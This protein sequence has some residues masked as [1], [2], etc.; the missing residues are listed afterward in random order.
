MYLA[1]ANGYC[2]PL[3]EGKL[4]P[5]RRHGAPHDGRDQPLPGLIRTEPAFAGGQ[6]L[7]HTLAR[8]LTLVERL[9]ELVVDRG[10]LIKGGEHRLGAVAGQPL[11]VLLEQCRNPLRPRGRFMATVPRERAV[12][13]RGVAEVGLDYFGSRALDDRMPDAHAKG[14][15]H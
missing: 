4:D 13:V 1:V 10:Y 6:D 2:A 7:D 11:L 5:L 12:E 15:Q 14:L 8:M 9:Q 3:I